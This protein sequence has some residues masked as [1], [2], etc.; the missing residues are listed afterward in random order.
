M[1]SRRNEVPQ[2]FWPDLG[3]HPRPLSPDWW[4][5]WPC[6]KRMIAF[7]ARLVPCRSNP[8]T[9]ALGNGSLGPVHLGTTRI[10]ASTETTSCGWFHLR[11][12]LR[13]KSAAVK[14]GCCVTW[15]E[16][17][18]RPSDSTSQLCSPERRPPIRRL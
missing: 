11:V 17:G 13:S 6:R 18:I 4:I 12:V 15:F 2:K 10:G 5:L 1:P 8:G 9:G 3:T 7:Q 16:L 14:A